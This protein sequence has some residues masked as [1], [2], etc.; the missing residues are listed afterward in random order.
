[1]RLSTLTRLPVSTEH[2]WP[3]IEDLHPRLGKLFA[4]LIMPL[5]LLPPLMLYYAGSLHPGIFPAHFADKDWGGIAVLFFLAEMGTVAFMGWF[6]REVAQTNRMHIDYYDAY[7]L[8]ALAPIPLWLSALG[9]FVPSLAFNAGLAIVALG[10]SCGIIYH[11]IMGLGHTREDVA[12][13]GLVQTVIGAGLVAWALLLL[14]IV[15]M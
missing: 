1:M 12:A 6:I 4:F 3:E 14:L 7:L 8:A 15:L 9:L 13:A 10:F 5:S 11:G 2:G